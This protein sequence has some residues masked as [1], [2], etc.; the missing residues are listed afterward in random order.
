M[1]T[2]EEI[3]KDI[4]SFVN[5][6]FTDAYG[7]MVTG[8]FVTEYFNEYS[9]IDIIILSGL[10]RK[11]YIDT[12]K[13]HGL[14]MQA[15]VFPVFDLRSVLSRDIEFGGIYLNQIQKGQIIKDKNNLFHDFKA[16]ADAIYMQ[17]PCNLT[18]Y[19]FD[20]ARARITTRIEDIE[21]NDNYE[22][23]IFTILDL[24]PRVLDLYFKANAK[25]S[26]SGKS[27]SRFLRDTDFEF[28]EKY[29]SSL[30]EYIRKGNKEK[31]LT[32]LKDFLQSVGGE[33]HYF[34]TREYTKVDTANCLVVF[35][36]SNYSRQ[37]IEPLNQIAEKAKNFICKHVD[38]VEMFSYI[39][40]DR[41][42]YSSGLYMLFFCDKDK[43][44]DE[45]LPLI[46]AFHIDLNNSN[47]RNFC[48]NFYYPYI[49]NPLDVFGD[50]DMQKLIVKLVN[51]L[52]KKK[53]CDN[54]IYAYNVLRHI[55]R[56]SFF[57]DDKMRKSFLKLCYDILDVT[58]S[59]F[60]ISK[61]IQKYYTENALA[62]HSHNYQKFAEKVSNI[63]DAGM[64]WVVSDVE[65]ISEMY[66]NNIKYTTKFSVE[67]LSDDPVLK[68]NVSFCIF[69]VN[70][71]EVILNSF[72]NNKNS[73][74]FIIYSLLRSIN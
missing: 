16:Y 49:N 69:L 64:A 5:E 31:V 45:V 32:F 11:V 2:K 20:Q 12:F 74:Q 19:G 71:I 46:E 22:D 41:R 8:S 33:M 51:N 28:Y 36:P 23:N 21:G 42:V 68:G 44:N 47:Y 34:T 3:W 55:L 50:E 10:F 30:N 1:K 56:I 65:T 9:D 39:Y 43:I 60:Y 67:S 57:E 58:D 37:A 13:Y 62:V 66:D 54:D 53:N 38:G 72:L 52:R 61:E 25:W 7:V 40:P 24:Y 27:A 73:K 18:K 26:F 63:G 17:G 59:T 48:Q 14:K 4:Y 15:I 35:I 29:L 70:F 6:Y